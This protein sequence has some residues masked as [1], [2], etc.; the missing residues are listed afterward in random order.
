MQVNIYILQ[1]KGSQKFDILYITKTEVEESKPFLEDW[2]A[3]LESYS[4]YSQMH[5]LKYYGNN[6]H[7]SETSDCTRFTVV[8]AF[9]DSNFALSKF[10]II[11]SMLTR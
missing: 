7:I 2:F 3:N 4:G 11:K 5:C 8:K 6:I 1:D 10:F 9:I